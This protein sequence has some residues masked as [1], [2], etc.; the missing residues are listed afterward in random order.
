MDE[1]K[2]EEEEEE[3]NPQVVTFSKQSEP[4]ANELALSAGKLSA[5]PYLNNFTNCSWKHFELIHMQG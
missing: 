1:E 3:V 4:N 5:F 2:Q